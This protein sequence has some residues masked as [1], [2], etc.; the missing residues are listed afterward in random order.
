MGTI[1]EIY[2][3]CGS[4]LTLRKK[5][6]LSQQTI[7]KVKEKIPVYHTRSMRQV[8]QSKFGRV[9]AGIKPC[10]L[11][12]LYKDLTND[13]SSP[14][15]VTEAEIDERMR[16]LLE[17]EDPDVVVDLRHLNS[18]Q[19]SKYDVFGSECQKF[20]QEDVGSA[21]DDQRHHCVTHMAKASTVGDLIEQVNARLPA[22]TLVPSQSW[23]RLQFWPKNRHAHSRIHYSGKLNIRFMVQ[24]RQFQKTHPDTHYAA[25]LFK[26][27]RECAVLFRDDCAFLY[28]DDKHR[29]KVGEPGFPVAAA[30]RW[31][32]VLVVRDS[33]FEVGDHDFTYKSIVPSVS[34]ILDVPETVDDSW[35]SGKVL[36]GLK[37]ATF[38]PSSSERHMAELHSLLVL[39]GLDIKPILFCTQMEDR[40]IG[41]PIFQCRCP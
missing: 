28:L 7:E 22:E 11:R 3:F 19:K 26:Y 24:G 39:Q 36:V 41:L 6:S 16:M 17:M 33:T 15:N 25:A 27:Q 18:G 13:H 32:R 30:V 34:F 4:V 31:R 40:T 2:T 9:T 21:V 35:Y 20:L 14:S 1:L 29:V 5:T 10:V 23:I 12:A 38:E 8:W 37:D